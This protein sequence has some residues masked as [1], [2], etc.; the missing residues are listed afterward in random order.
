MKSSKN[1][2]RV[3]RVDTLRVPCG[4]N[5]IAYIGSSFTEAKK[6]YSELD[7]GLDAWNQ[8]DSAYGVILSVWDWGDREYVIKCSKGV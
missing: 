8:P 3:D 4:M 7:V 6:I 2:F 1:N 5:S